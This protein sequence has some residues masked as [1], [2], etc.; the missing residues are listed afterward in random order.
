MYVRQSDLFWGM[1]RDFVKAIMDIAIKE[2]HKGGDFLFRKGDRANHFYILL[3]G[4]VKLA[5][6]DAGEVAYIVDRAG[7]AFGWSSLAELD[8]YSASAECM[9]ATT[10][11]RIERQK[12]QRI[13][14]GDPANGLIFFK[15]L[16]GLIGN[17]LLWSYKMLTASAQAEISTSFGTEQLQESEA[18]R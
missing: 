2:S 5:I 9:E 3:T 10:L 15:R 17:R 13:L 1:G 6:G 18:V 12:I 8:S 14:E 4:R 7:E 16:T 11:Q